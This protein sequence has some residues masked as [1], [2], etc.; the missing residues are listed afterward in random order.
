MIEWAS[1]LD[2]ANPVA[3]ASDADIAG[4]NRDALQSLS[5]AEVE[6]VDASCLGVMMT[7]FHSL[8]TCSRP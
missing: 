2:E 5:A 7:S 3:G 4:L 1:I 8:T 6:A